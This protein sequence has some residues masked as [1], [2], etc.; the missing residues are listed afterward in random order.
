MAQPTLT[1]NHLSLFDEEEEEEEDDGDI[2]QSIGRGTPLRNASRAPASTTRTTTSATT[3]SATTTATAIDATTYH[4]KIHINKKF[5][6]EY[7]QRK[8]R[9]ELRQKAKL[10]EDTAT[11]TGTIGRS[12]EKS[13]RTR[14]KENGGG[15]LG[16]SNNDDDTSSL[17]T[18]ST[19]SSSEDEDGRLLT[20]SLDVQIM[21]TLNALKNKEDIIYNPSTC[22][23]DTNT[24]DDDDDD[25]ENGSQRV[26]RD[27]RNRIL[28]VKASATSKPKRYK[29]VVRE[30]I[31]E[32][33]E[34]DEAHDESDDANST[35][36][37][38]KEGEAGVLRNNASRYAYNMEQKDLREA[39][40]KSV[41]D[42]IRG[43]DDDDDESDSKDAFIVVKPTRKSANKNGKEAIF[44]DRVGHEDEDREEFA[45]EIERLKQTL[46]K[47][48]KENSTIIDPRGEVQDG[49]AFLIDF[50]EKR[51]W[52]M[53]ETEN[54]EASSDADEYLDD[55]PDETKWE[56]SKHYDDAVDDGDDQSLNE[57]DKA[58]DF[59]AQYN[60]RFEQASSN[61]PSGAELSNLSYARGLT[62]QTL[63][64]KDESRRERRLARKEKKELE[65][66]AKEEE[67]R[68]LKNA[69]RQEMSEKLN[70]VKA[71]LGSVQD[72][73]AVD[74]ATLL[75]L[76][77]G[78]YD[79]DK[80]EELMNA[81]YGDEFYEKPDTQWRSDQDVRESLKDDEDIALLVNQDDDGGLYDDSRPS[82]NDDD[83]GDAGEEQDDLGEE[84]D[85]VEEEYYDDDEPETAPESEIERKLKNKMMEELYKL[86][87]EDIV[88]GMP[89]RFKYRT[90]EPNNY[91]LSTEEILF[92]KDSTLK[93]FVSL[94]KLAPYREGGEFLVS[95]KKRR[96]FREF[97]K[98]DFE[99]VHGKMEAGKVDTIA[100]NVD[101][102]TNGQRTRRRKR[103]KKRS[104]EVTPPEQEKSVMS[105][106]IS[107][108]GPIQETGGERKAK[109]R[110]KKK[111]AASSEATEGSRPSV[112][113]EE[114]TYQDPASV[115][116]ALSYLTPKE[117]LSDK[118][119]T[120]MKTAKKK[121]RNSNR[122]VE[123]LSQSRLASY[124]L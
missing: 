70:Q 44:H 99:E 13:K 85:N 80:F 63:R 5:A 96:Q 73:S 71:I 121:R 107:S 47:R 89:T 52:M 16:D 84:A 117:G 49:E 86:D 122:I 7:Q 111:I 34:K 46:P 14:N 45:R 57:L 41:D 32:Q 28:S 69:K 12:K 35:D 31:L 66:Q 20:D 48:Q 26:E 36:S 17:G 123:G 6:K 90:V 23:F 116:N 55:D 91:G 1:R 124:G 72:S 10:L 65:R 93:Q 103:G 8:Q 4:D 58:D 120:R 27:T 68:R 102:S 42:A 75:K 3:G 98:R 94:K 67:L 61:V 104:I 105:N 18:T 51:P 38:V 77:E 39:F 24:D 92:A 40:L 56:T 110:R 108:G 95:K 15:R 29:D 2:D 82:D 78:D 88:A 114:T 54:D 59:E 19:T 106:S 30:Q 74:E 119:K 64:R 115:T 83:N 43:D 11:T 118:A 37:E 101:A 25:D 9:E 87:Y 97:L 100:T 53:K 60:F 21:K 79:P 113:T 50:F 62:M 22:F 76:L 33:M 81:T 112:P 109:R